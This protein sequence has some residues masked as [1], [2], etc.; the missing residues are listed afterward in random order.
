M[1]S[2]TFLYPAFM[3]PIV[4]YFLFCVKYIITVKVICFDRFL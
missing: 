3:D 1:I 4:S 2:P